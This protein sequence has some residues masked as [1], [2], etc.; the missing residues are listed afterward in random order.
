MWIWST[1]FDSEATNVAHLDDYLVLPLWNV[2][3]TR[4]F[5]GLACITRTSLV[6]DTPILDFSL[7]TERTLRRA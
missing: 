4:S 7:F 3:K 6:Y 2:S 5:I 1:K